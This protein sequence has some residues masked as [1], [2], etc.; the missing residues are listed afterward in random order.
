MC[1]LK[2][3]LGGFVKNSWTNGYYHDGKGKIL[4][5]VVL[6]DDRYKAMLDKMFIGWYI[7]EDHAKSAIEEAHQDSIGTTTQRAE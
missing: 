4:G 2:L 1:F 5:S 7:T 3:T 6:F